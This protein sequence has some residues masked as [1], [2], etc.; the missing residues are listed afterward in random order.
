MQGRG[1][2]E[3][4]RAKSQSGVVPDAPDNMR[5]HPDVACLGCL[6]SGDV[7]CILVSQDTNLGGAQA[8]VIVT[9]GG[10]LGSDPGFLTV[11]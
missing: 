5:C 2:V 6:L 7:F 9:G 3:N 8:C 11:L 4:L 1:R 10:E